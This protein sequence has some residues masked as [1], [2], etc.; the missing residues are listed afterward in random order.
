MDVPE[1]YRAPPFV[2]NMLRLNVLLPWDGDVVFMV[3]RG[4]SMR[5]GIMALMS[6]FLVPLYLLWQ[7]SGSFDFLNA[8]VSVIA[9]R[10]IALGQSSNI[11]ALDLVLG[12]VLV[13]AALILLL[14]S[15]GSER[16]S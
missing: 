13:V 2:G 11:Y 5:A 16:T 12:T 14:R 3:E 7:G 10:S 1:Q 15:H 9:V 6:I 8:A 4:R